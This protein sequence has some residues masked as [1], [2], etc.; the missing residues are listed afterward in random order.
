MEQLAQPFTI[1]IKHR[2]K[3]VS[4]NIPVTE[5]G[6]SIDVQDQGIEISTTPQEEPL[7]EAT[8]TPL[9]RE[10]IISRLKQDPIL[11]SMYEAFGIPDTPTKTK[12]QLIAIGAYIESLLTE[13]EMK[14][15]TGEVTHAEEEVEEEEEAEEEPYEIDMEEDT[16][17]PL[18]LPPKE[19]KK[20]ILQKV[21]SLEKEK[22]E[23]KAKP[24][25]KKSFNSLFEVSM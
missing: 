8:E 6:I 23:E 11:T 2:G 1:L 12:R 4:I 15:Y 3:E 7:Q 14:I 24:V 20:A 25:V 16:E 17:E 18:Q 19:E 10:S 5:K 22:K 13:E 9:T 21:S